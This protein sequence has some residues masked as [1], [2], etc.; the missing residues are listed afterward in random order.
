MLQCEVDLENAPALWT[1]DDVPLDSNH[2]AF[3]RLDISCVGKV[4]A[5]K[6]RDLLDSDSG[7]YKFSV[8]DKQCS[9]EISVEGSFRARENTQSTLQTHDHLHILSKIMQFI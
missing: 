8:G 4:H 7:V 3:S 9:S 1:K 2:P 6:M 5:L